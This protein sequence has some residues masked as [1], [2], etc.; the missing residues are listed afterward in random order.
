MVLL[1]DS[2][3]GSLGCGSLV[4]SAGPPSPSDKD[5]SAAILPS[6]HPVSNPDPI[7]TP[8]DHGTLMSSLRNLSH[9]IGPLC[10]VSSTQEFSS[11]ELP[12]GWLLGG[13]VVAGGGMGGGEWESVL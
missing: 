10:L 8:S 6:H 5:S 3:E 12:G 4:S 2:Q 9:N 1:L 13:R 11:S 7:L